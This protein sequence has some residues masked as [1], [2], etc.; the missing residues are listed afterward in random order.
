MA[1]NAPQLAIA[2]NL[3][4][5]GTVKERKMEEKDTPECR[6]EGIAELMQQQ[7]TRLFNGAG[8]LRLAELSLIEGHLRANERILQAAEERQTIVRTSTNEAEPPNDATNM[9]L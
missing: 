9:P 7:A 8:Q 1:V 6:A 3:P 2:E 5:D 4:I